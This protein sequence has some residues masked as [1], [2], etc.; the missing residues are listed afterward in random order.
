MAKLKFRSEVPPLG[1]W[2]IQ[3]E[4]LLRIEGDSLRDLTEKVIAH[5]KYKGFEPTD[6]PTV[7]LEVERQI[8]ARLGTYHCNPEGPED[9][10]EPM[11]TASTMIKAGSVLAFSRAAFA[12]LAGGME[13][14]PAEKAAARAEKCRGCPIN[15]PLTGCKCGGVMQTIQ[16]AV[17]KE[18]LLP[19]LGVCMV[20]ECSLPAKVWLPRAVIDASNKGR[21][22]KFPRDGSCWQADPEG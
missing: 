12:W 15:W 8:C 18:K 16:A 10:W 19:G 14:V 1:F 9:R 2:F 5:R 11:Q 13:T 17:P 6:Y 22:L 21:D 4:T 3:K 20:C 7:E